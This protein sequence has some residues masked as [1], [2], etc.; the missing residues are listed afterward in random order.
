MKFSYNWLK[1][2]AK[3]RESPK[4]L[5]EFLALRAFEVE[6]VVKKG[7][8]WVLDVKLLPNRAADA[9]GHWGLAREIATLKNSEFRTQNLELNENK[10]QRAS[11]ALQ[12]KI[13]NPAD[14]PRYTAR[15]ME[16]VKVSPSPKWMRERLEA[17]GIQS[18]SSIVDAA[19]YVMLELGQ[20][21]HVFGAAEIKGNT[22]IVRRAKK[23]EALLALDEKTYPLSPEILV[24][25][26][27]KDPIA[28]AGIKGGK[29]S[30]VSAGTTAIILESANFDPVRTRISSRLLGLKTDASYRFE[31]GM[32]P[33][34][35]AEAIDRLA[36]V[37]REVAG[38]EVLAGRVDAYPK[39][40]R[41]AKILLRT[42][43]A[44]RLIGEEVPADFC[45]S[46]FRRLGWNFERKSALE[47]I[48]EPPTSRRD[49][50]IEEDVIEE[51]VR[52]WGYENVQAHAPETRLAPAPPNEAHLW[53]NRVRDILVGAGFT[54][55][56][57]Y[58]F[59]SRRAAEDFGDSAER[60]LELENPT[61]PDTQFLGAEP[62]WTY[63]RIAAENLRRAD[64]VN[65]FGIAKGFLPQAKPSSAM[66]AIETTYLV[67]A[68]AAKVTKATKGTKETGDS[69]TFY[70]VKGVV[71]QLL[72]S[73]GIA[74]HWYDDALSAT[75]KKKLEAF[76]PYRIAQVK[77]DDE[78]LGIVG[79]LHPDVQER[80]KSKARIVIAQLNFEKLWQRARAEAEFKPIGRFPAIIRDIAVIVPENEKADT[81]QGILENACGELLADTDL[82][83]YYADG[84]MEQRGEK[85]LAFHLIFQSPERT[86]TDAE[87]SRLYA[88]VAAALR[89]KGWEV[90][91]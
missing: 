40:L 71:D 24:I 46:L 23:E 43:Y 32:D 45:E 27:G 89:E 91:E 41:P 64:S 15:V 17:C 70:T 69:E 67:I 62:A 81:V 52:L 75:E 88:K 55:A 74:E 7:G 34:G 54:E 39:H 3:F 58:V 61:S 38:G 86:L 76:H 79:E 60:L 21:L 44:N 83:D 50:Q 77:A 53:E 12:V 57:A 63:A 16:G 30:G 29:H 73:L 78:L 90:R 5:A 20:P 49:I 56:Y 87:V 28:I 37:I 42:G 59:T 18:I 82:F 48:V 51:I 47:Y 19:N 2:L 84:A 36:E 22:I 68:K 80:L 10:S 14:C 6:S 26:D 11:D 85:S 65:L 8:D 1:E 25:A 66:P 9:A 72:E 13:E 35:T 33:N 31:R 4:A